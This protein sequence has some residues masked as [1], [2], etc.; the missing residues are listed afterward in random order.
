[1]ALD[2]HFAPFLT[3]PAIFINQK[4]A[5]F[6]AHEFLATQRLEL[7]R[8]VARSCTLKVRDDAIQCGPRQFPVSLYMASYAFTGSRIESRLSCSQRSRNSSRNCAIGVDPGI[9]IVIC[10]ENMGAPVWAAA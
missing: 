7:H 9:L 5:A 3:K 2:L 6:N 4:S 8:P 1:M 10:T